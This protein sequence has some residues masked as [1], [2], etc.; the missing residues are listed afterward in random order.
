MLAAE[1]DKADGATTRAELVESILEL[2]QVLQEAV[3]EKQYGD[4]SSRVD[5][6]DW[7]TDGHEFIDKR[8]Y[9]HRVSPSLACDDGLL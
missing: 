7:R 8:M 2:E 4:L 9:D 3:L 5:L 1:Q 6:D